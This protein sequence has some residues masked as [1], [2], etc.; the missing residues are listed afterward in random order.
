MGVGCRLWRSSFVQGSILGVLLTPQL[1]AFATPL[2]CLRLCAANMA[3]LNTCLISS[4]QVTFCVVQVAAHGHGLYY[5]RVGA[6]T[7]RMFSNSVSIFCAF[8]LIL[9]YAEKKLNPRACA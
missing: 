7:S 6:Q 8:G 5:G 4:P 2:N 3:E 9:C 1:S